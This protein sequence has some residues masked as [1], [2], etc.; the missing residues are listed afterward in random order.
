VTVETSVK[1]TY[2]VTGPDAVSMVEL[3]Q[4]IGAALHRRVRIARVPMGLMR[5][6]A[7]VLHRT[8]SFPVSPDQLLML[9]EDNTGDPTPFY[10]TFG[11]T[12]IPLAQGLR[13]VL[14]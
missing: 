1:Q 3:L 9:E 5:P 12:P 14:G 7:R 2:A 10:T 13:Q 8:P 6:M 4:L 11:L